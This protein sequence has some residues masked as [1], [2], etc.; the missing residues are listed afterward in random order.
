MREGRYRRRTPERQYG[1]PMREA[2]KERVEG[3]P[4]NI[5][6]DEVEEIGIKIGLEN[7]SEAARLFDRLKGVSWR[8]EY[9][10]SDENGWAAARVVEVN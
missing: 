9:V 5:S 8:G 2:L 6:R 10:G 7:P 3:G 1:G 4:T